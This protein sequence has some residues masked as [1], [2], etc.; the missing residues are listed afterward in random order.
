MDYAGVRTL[1]ASLLRL[2]RHGWSD[3]A[4]RVLHPEKIV[5]RL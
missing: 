5:N 2:F 1:T 3:E 4:V